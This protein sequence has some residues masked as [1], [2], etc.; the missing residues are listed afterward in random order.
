MKNNKIIIA[1]GTGFIGQEMIRYFGKENNIV[2]LTR[3]LKDS[4]NNRNHYSSLDSRDTQNVKFVKWDG[5]TAAEWVKE[6]ENA[7]L[8][9][10][11]AGKSVNCRYT[12]KNKKE[13][14]DS[15]IDS[16][17]AIWCCYTAM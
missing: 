10:N 1:G 12:E 4:T 3:Q 14:F 15:R 9:I 7:D 5:K 17:K 8:I 6:L 11:L 16:V 13:I 2:V